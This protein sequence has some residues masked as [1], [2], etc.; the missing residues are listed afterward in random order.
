MSE[1]TSG[2][3][4][5]GSSAAPDLERG[6]LEK[7]EQEESL[8]ADVTY[9][10][11]RRE[12][13]QELERPTSA[14]AWSGLAAGLAMGLSFITVA[15][16]SAKLPDEPWRPLVSSFGYPVGFLIVILASQQLFTENT[17]KAIVPLLAHPGAG[18]LANVARLWSVVFL[19]NLVGALL[20]AW[21]IGAA[22][23]FP[24][25]VRA[26]LVETARK[27]VEHGFVTTLVKAV[28]AGWLV[29]I[30]VW[31]LPA[32]Q[33]SQVLV[34]LIVGW[35]IAAGEFLH[36]VAGASEVFYLAMHGELAWGA[37]VTRFLAPV[38]LGNVIGGV[39][40]VSA[41]NHAQVVAGGGTGES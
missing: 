32:A 12:G 16:L 30:L 34:I 8:N 20:F 39:T 27:A 19:A 10:V 5:A 29:A 31:M 3:P 4:D 41:I 6:E 17:L 25:E 40:I 2:G 18:M 15:I 9:E 22:E 37:T 23:L 7:A 11:I 35:L 13:V 21:M 1:T 26:A 24:P 28:F 38:L 36:V 14:L 33:T